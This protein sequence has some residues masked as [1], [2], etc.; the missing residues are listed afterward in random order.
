MSIANQ[1]ITKLRSL[2]LSAM[3]EAYQSQIKQPKLH[4][5]GFDDRFAMLVDFEESERLSKKL[6]RLIKVAKF[7]ESAS[8]EDINEH[9]SRGVDKKQI[10]S[11]ANCEWIRKQLNLIIVGP[12]GVGKTWLA[13]AFGSQACR[14]NIPTM[15][16]RCSS[17]YS[18]IMTSVRDGSLPNLK[19][20]LIKPP[21]LILDDF[22]MRTMTSEV[23]ETL[24]EIMDDRVRSGSL[25]ITSQYPTDQWHTHFPD[26]TLADAILD[27][28][29]HS[30][31]R[32]NLKGESMRK[33]QARRRMQEP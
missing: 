29:I 20:K 2:R 13:S 9:A 21:L 15:Y 19:T 6:K 22:G 27:R 18:D 5:I 30:S 33:V 17:L 25:I 14:Q 28:L 12:T 31:H 23:A 1:T 32:I 7:P 4:Q 8:L 10:A 3:A 26:P 16:Y 24:Y 11:L